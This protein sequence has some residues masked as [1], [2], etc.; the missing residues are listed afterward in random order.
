MASPLLAKRYA[1]ALS[2]LSSEEDSLQEVAEN[3]SLVTSVLKGSEE[4]RD[5]LLNPVFAIQE[6]M[7]VLKEISDYLKIDDIT[8][9]FLSVL[10][11]NK[12]FDHIDM[13]EKIFKRLVDRKLNRIQVVVS[14]AHPVD[15]KI[16]K[17]L[18]K[19]FEA[20]TNREAVIQYQIDPKLIGGLVFK[21]GSL[22]FDSSIAN[23]LD[24]LALSF[25]REL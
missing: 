6:R 23:Q 19:I 7:G 14:T 11:Q 8:E 10:L 9:K 22:V 3:L 5:A 15:K 25:R 12:R 1:K 21:M 4:L 20:L 18:E 13:V 17:N 16:S 24:N 2:E